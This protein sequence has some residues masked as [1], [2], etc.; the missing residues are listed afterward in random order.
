[1]VWTHFAAINAAKANY[2]ASHESVFYIGT[3]AEGL[4]TNTEPA[5]PDLM[6]VDSLSMMHGN[7]F[8]KRS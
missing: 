3:L 1:M 7:L 2:A 4:T 5:M 6:H 8:A